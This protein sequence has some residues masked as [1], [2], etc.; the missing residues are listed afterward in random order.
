[1]LKILQSW[2]N[3]CQFNRS[4]LEQLLIEILEQPQLAAAFNINQNNGL[5]ELKKRADLFLIVAEIVLE[6]CDNL[7][8]RNLD[9]N[10]TTLWHLWL[11]LALQLSQEKDKLER[12]LIQGIL[13][14]QGTGK[15]TLTTILN[16]ILSHLGKTTL[17]LSIDDL[18]KT[19]QERQQL[20]QED[21]RLIWRGPP[22][23]HDV[24]LGINILEKLRQNQSSEPIS[25]PRF[26]KSAYNGAGDRN[27]PELVKKADIV[28]FEG[29]FVGVQPVDESVFDNPLPPIITSEDKQFAIDSNQ[30]LREYLPLW[31]KIDRL[32]VLYPEDYHLSKQWRT[33][34]EH[35]MIALGKTGM[36]DEQINQFVEYF[37]RSLHPEL[38]ITP[39]IKNHDLT[40]LVIEIK[41]DRTLGKIYK[42]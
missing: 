18:Y 37:W 25:I 4:E 28:L 31:E 30:R 26:D 6:L 29:W 33:E 5:E 10:L 19:Y 22:G 27:T 12:T 21:S 32:I 39:L 20:Q 15:T 36:T 35:K 1:M 38:F 3:Q 23:T 16:L 9:Y 24:Q 8:L 34:A 42:P 40:N 11:P 17:D 7:K 14:G 13:G 2:L 41:P